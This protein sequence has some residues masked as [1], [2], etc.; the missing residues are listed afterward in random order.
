MP[1]I[2]GIEATR[3]IIEAHPDTVVF[4]CSTYQ[5]EPTCR[6]RRRPAGAAA[7][8]NKEELAPAVIAD[9]WARRAEGWAT[10]TS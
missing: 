5:H 8:V 7:Y 10:V 4:L 2:N 3:Q 1:G 6:R 9:L